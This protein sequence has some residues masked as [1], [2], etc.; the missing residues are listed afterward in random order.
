M[1]GI[2]HENIQFGRRNYWV[3]PALEHTPTF[4]GEC[5]NTY[6]IHS[7]ESAVLHACEFG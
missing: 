7:G 3:S 6:S 2:W 4:M 1:R 5:M